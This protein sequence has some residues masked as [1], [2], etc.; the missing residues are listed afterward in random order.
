M[1][2]IDYALPVASAQVKSAVLLAG[3]FGDGA[4]DGGRAAADARPHRADAGAAGARVV[5]RPSS[6]SVDPAERLRLE[7]IEVPGDFSSAAPL[8]VAAAI[9]PGSDLTVHG[10]GL[11]PRAPGLLDVLE[12]MGARIAVYNRHRAGDEPVGDV[13]VRA[14]RSWPR[15]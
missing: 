8:L 4:H 6:A 5:R 7:R 2:A 13:E 1:H 12:R 15:P 10:V 14:R 9:V 11:N 3:L